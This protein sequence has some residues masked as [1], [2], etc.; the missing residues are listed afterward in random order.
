MSML[1]LIVRNEV[2]GVEY[3]ISFILIESV[4]VVILIVLVLVLTC[5]RPFLQNMFYISIFMDIL[6]LV[7]RDIIIDF[8]M[9]VS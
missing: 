9:Q 1:E 4:M 7:C 8:S 3:L 2:E 6:F 5:N